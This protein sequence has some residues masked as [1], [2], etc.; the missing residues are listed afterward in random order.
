MES[1]NMETVLGKHWH[2][3]QAD[4]VVDLLDSHSEKGLDVLEVLERREHFGPNTVPAPRDRGRSYGFSC[5][6]INRWSTSCSA[7]VAS[8]RC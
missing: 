6:S 3:H 7:P 1:S 5:S 4:E 2:H 8:R